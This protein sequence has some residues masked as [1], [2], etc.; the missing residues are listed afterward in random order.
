MQGQ[1]QVTLHA[2]SDRTRLLMT[3]SSLGQD[4]VKAIL[5]PASIAHPRAAATLLEGL[6]LWHQKPLCVVLCVDDGQLSSAESLRL[7]DALGYGVQQL[8]FEVAVACGPRR[9]S[10]PER[11]QGVGDFRDMRQ[12]RFDEVL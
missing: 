6:S 12:L 9:R 10:R 3:D 4:V 7:Y 5:P 8:H 2:R 11:I 1:L